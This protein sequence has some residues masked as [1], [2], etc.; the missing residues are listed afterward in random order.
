MKP[1]HPSSSHNN[2]MLHRLARVH[3]IQPT[4]RDEGGT[5][6][7]VSPKSLKTILGLMG[8]TVN[9]PEAIRQA[10]KNQELDSWRHLLPATLVLPQATRAIQCPLHIPIGQIATKN[11]T[12]HWTLR[13]GDTIT[14]RQTV[15]GHR[16]PIQATRRIQGSPHIRLLL[17]IAPS[18]P[19]G[20]FQLQVTL[21]GLKS[22]CQG[23]STIIIV[24]QSAFQLPALIKG[25]RK[26]GI[27]IQLYGLR[28]R[29]NW[30]IGDFHDL[31]EF[32]TWAGRTL[33]ADM[34]GVNPLHALLPG[35]ISPYSP[36]S[37]LF[38]NALYLHIEDI[39]EFRQSPLI[40]KLVFGKNF[41]TQLEALRKSST[42][43]Y[44]AMA[45]LKW[46][47]LE[48]LYDTFLH[49]H[50]KPRT[51]RGMA[52]LK[53]TEEKG[54]DLERFACFQTLFE[55]FSKTSQYAKGWRAWPTKYRTPNSPHVQQ[56]CAQQ[57]TRINF[58]RYVE[59][60]CHVQLQ[61]VQQAAR[62]AGM[63]IGLYQD[64]AVGLHPQG[65]D[66]W[67]FQDQLVPQASIGTP[68]ELFSPK[69]QNWTLVPLSPE[70]LPRSGYQAFI[71]TYR[72][73]MQECG[74]LR[75]DHAMGL[76]RFFWIPNG[77]LPKDGAYVHYPAE[78]LLGILTLEST[79]AHCMI[80]GEDLG[81]ITPLIRRSLQNAGL[82]SY[83]LLLFEKTKNGNF[84]PPSRYP[85]Q[86]MIACT[87]H[88]LPTL[89]GFWLGRDIEWKRTLGLYPR[90]AMADKDWEV[91]MQEKTALLKALK[92]EKV[93][94]KEF[95]Q[96][97]PSSS[98][99]P[100][101]YQAVYT[102]LARTPS[103]LMTIS[104]EDLL[105]DLETPNIPGASPE[106]YPV[107]QLKSGP[108]KESFETWKNWPTVKKLAYTIN[109]ERKRKSP[110]FSR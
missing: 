58:F 56:W 65:S 1:S 34:V 16:V 59:W 21:Q 103:W 12:I 89:R 6:R 19:I 41:Q 81:T 97:Q 94:I 96:Q 15:Q 8:I 35:E 32:I 42:V 39:D 14:R 20:Y 74:L 82:L 98:L 102:F 63:S 51:R 57:G 11:L 90:L 4:F 69:G 67:S 78:D 44:E 106:K 76:F 52:F 47:I 26:W 5:L 31:R 88:D 50:L 79:R 38:H 43:Q 24:P 93:W 29:D 55:K 13:E 64:L 92:K 108:V 77:S 84:L 86:A 87:T 46:N 18:L 109:Q 91:R 73:L 85:Q 22:T 33:G 17:P 110:T 75:I 48:Q 100:E 2:T 72:Q 80:V 36:S 28:T 104:L 45:K 3:G 37:R 54:T 30:G 25:Q 107:W 61:R 40:Q 95:I 60:Q 62:K 71:D 49:R 27:T 9:S 99:T 101:L 68:P 53:F 10:L 23:T 66:A 70:A 7:T 105:G 83:R